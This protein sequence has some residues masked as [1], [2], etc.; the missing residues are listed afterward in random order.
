MTRYSSTAK[1]CKPRRHDDAFVCLRNWAPTG[2][3]A[4][5]FPHP[6]SMPLDLRAAT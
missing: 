5:T 1:G 2:V 6:Y 4:H 3:Y